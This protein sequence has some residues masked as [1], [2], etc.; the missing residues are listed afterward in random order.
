VVIPVRA[1]TPPLLSERGTI[2]LILLLAL[3][4]RI[5][6][7]IW[8][9]QK[10]IWLDGQRYYLVALRLFDG[11]G[12]GSLFDN[13]KSVPTQPLVIAAV[14]EIFRENFLAFRITF[15]VLGAL[16]CTVGYYVA[17]RLFGAVTA[18]IAGLLL[19]LYPFLVYVSALFEYPQTLYILL[20]GLFFLFLLRFEETQKA[21]NLLGA[22][23]FLGLAVLTVPTMLLYVPLAALSVGWIATTHRLVR[24]LILIAAFCVP[25]GAWTLRNYIAYDRFMLVN[26]SSGYNFLIANSDAYYRYGKAGIL[27]IPGDTTT[28]GCTEQTVEALPSGD[29]TPFV[30]E[31]ERVAWKAGIGFVQESP[32]RFLELTL[33]RFLAFWSPAPDAFTTDSGS[34]ASIR[35]WVAAVTYT[36]ILLL[37]AAGL[38]LTRSQW[39]RLLPIYGYFLVLTAAHSV[40]LPTAR[41]RLPLDFFLMMFAAEALRQILLRLRSTTGRQILVPISSR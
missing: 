8:L 29:L 31:Q 10:I 19:A 15:A 22:G 14:Y 24:M 13:S 27:C 41:Y 26:A 17:R 30:L 6:V 5:A 7:A 18:C 25:V 39:R 2:L 9:P 35:N 21:R 1:S 38:L 3:A 11:Q 4:T 34:A 32:T 36:P 20:T 28:E 23:V 12:F 33:R 37:G 40:F 16:S